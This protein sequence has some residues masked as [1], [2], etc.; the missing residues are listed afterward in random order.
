MK[1]LLTLVAPV[2]LEEDLAD[3][4]LA[5]PE[6]AAGFTTLAALGHGASAHAQS[7][8]EEVSGRVAQTQ[9]QIVSDE[10][11]ARALLAA[12]QTQ[13]RIPG[14]AWWMSPITDFGSIE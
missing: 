3:F 11:A 4:L 2:A 10:A 13:S 7:I 8:A 9:F 5:H 1:T 12:L 6:W 14:L